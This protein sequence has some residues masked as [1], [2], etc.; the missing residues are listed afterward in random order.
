[1]AEVRETPIVK[2]ICGMISTRVELFEEAQKCLEKA[3]GPIDVESDVMDFDHTHYYDEQMGTPLLRKFIAFDKPA[4]PKVLPEMKLLTNS[5]ECDFASKAGP[6]PARPINLDPGYIELSKL[7]LA[8][9][10]NFSHRIYLDRG[11]FGEITLFYRQGNWEA[12]PWTFPDYASGQYHPFLTN[13][14]NRL[15]EHIDKEK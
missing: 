9:M 7:V 10:K 15:R 6:T 12:L 13:A 2:L 3:Y 14:R 1:M 5:L 8:S 11:V 4:T